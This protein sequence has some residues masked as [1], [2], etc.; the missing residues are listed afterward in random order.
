MNAFP[1]PNAIKSDSEALLDQA[2][3]WIWALLD[4]QLTETETKELSGLISENDVVRQRYLE[5][6]ALH[7][8]LEQHFA[9][10]RSEPAKSPVLGFLGS[11]E[12]ATG[13]HPPVA[14]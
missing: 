1:D 6:I 10:Q 7:A 4:D 9:G 12:P 3:Q 14:D 11:I 5:C 2:E 8:D 13:S